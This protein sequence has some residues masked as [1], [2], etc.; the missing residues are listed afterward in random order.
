MTGQTSLAGLLTRQWIG[1]G[2]V[3]LLGSS[4]FALLA[5]FVLED[6]FID[7]RLREVA[8]M[9]ADSPASPLPQ[10]YARL[11]QAQLD[12]ELLERT[13][14]MREG[15]IREFRL[16]DGRYLHVL[17]LP[18]PVHRPAFLLFEAKAALRV[19]QSLP[20]GLLVL[21][22]SATVLIGLAWLLATRF[23]NRLDSRMQALLS[24]AANND[25]GHAL[26][27]SAA[28]EPILELRALGL[29]LADAWQ[30]RLD[31]LARES[32]TL[33]FLAHELR[34]PLQSA[35][36][37]LALLRQQPGHAQAMARLQRAINRLSRGSHAVLLLASG[38]IEIPRRGSA[39]RPIVLA[40]LEE[41]A[42]M[43]DARAQC[44][45]LEIDVDAEWSLSE[46]VAETVLANL[47][48]NAISHGGAGSIHIQWAD[49][50]LSISNPLDVLHGDAGGSAG[51]GL[52]LELS[53][54]LLARFAWRLH[55][56]QHAD[57][58][59]T[60]LQTSVR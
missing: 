2:L 38:E 11:E 53:R 1:F 22:A 15:W 55:Q 51:F 5:L 19:N 23:V 14:G 29:A 28:A 39:I 10:G 17:A 18:T 9:H 31:A 37:S 54:R 50:E 48:L 57:R 6:S 44:F 30:A 60:R 32:E 43:A 24:A 35:R 12:T 40:L 47:I 13:H 7:A 8:A 3:I 21:L 4:S 52:G 41:F 59:V 26:R 42:A 45:A 16:R 56:A 36:G 25:C 46:E 34:T 49:N 58:M 33:A 20:R 27:L